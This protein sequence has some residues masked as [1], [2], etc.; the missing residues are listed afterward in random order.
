MKVITICGSLRFKDD[1]MYWSEKLEL[2]GNCVLGIIYPF[3]KS[4][5]KENWFTPEE[6]DTLDR[7]HKKKIDLSDAIFV[8]N[9]GGYVGNSTKSEIEY[10]KARGK[11][12][13]FMEN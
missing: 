10:A 9:K 13:L 4:G 1:I 8:V 3:N 7:G 2:A 6:E 12:V 11:E 5:G